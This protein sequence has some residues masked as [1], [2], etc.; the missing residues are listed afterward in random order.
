MMVDGNAAAQTLLSFGTCDPSLC[1][2]YVWIAY[3]TH[4]AEVDQSFATALDGWHGSSGKH[5]GDRNPPPGV[6]VW[7]GK[8]PDS[9]AGDVVI[10]LG[11]GRVAATDF[12][13]FGVIGIATIDERQ[14]QIGRE[15]LGWTETIL[16]APIDNA[17]IA[18]VLRPKEQN[19][20]YVI[21]PIAGTD[22]VHIVS[23][24]TGIR[25]HITSEFHL[26]LLRRLKK[27]DFDDEMLLAEIDV[28]RGYLTAVNP[29][30][31]VVIDAQAVADA[32]AQIGQ[33]VDA[34]T[35]NRLV[36]QAIT[37]NST[38]VVDPADGAL[39]NRL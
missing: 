8:R 23:L 3:A 30:P 22:E 32:L 1:L 38:I 29:P 36:N 27:N 25:A 4:G 7:W 26:S 9:D 5:E 19:M 11:G 17:A 39:S 16:G 28:V 10:S 18:A 14:E 2:H 21:V 13:G 20:S 6:P 33:N 15:Y 12:P 35:A 31:D 34:D 37:S 24:I